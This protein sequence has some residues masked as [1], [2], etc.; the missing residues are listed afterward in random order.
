MKCCMF[1]SNQV[2]ILFNHMMNDVGSLCLECYMKIQG[3]C[4]VCSDSFMPSEVKE[5]AT[6]NVRAKF[7]GMGERNII[8]CD[9]C[10]VEVQKR[11]P[12]KIM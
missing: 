9:S 2:E 10:Y 12:G 1:C 11:F 6:C 4:S 7:I 3:T 5:D 8:V